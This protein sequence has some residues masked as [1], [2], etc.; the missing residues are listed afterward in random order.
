VTSVALR[1]VVGLVGFA[2][3][4]SALTSA[5]ITL[6]L[7][8][9]GNTRTA[10][11][12]IRMTR[13]VLTRTAGR[14]SARRERALALLAPVALL[15]M[16]IA[17]L[18]QIWVGF[19]GLYLAAGLEPVGDTALDAVWRALFLSGSSLL[20]LGFATGD[21]VVH[22]LLT[23]TEATLGL[24]VVTLL[25]AYLPTMYAAF[26]QRETQV[27]LL[28]VRAGTP[29]SASEML[30]RYHRIGNDH[31]LG[32]AMLEWEEWFAQ[33]TETHTTLTTLPLFRSSDPSQSWVTAAGTVLDA[34]SLLH[35][36]V[37]DAPKAPAALCIRAGFLAL[38]AIADEWALPYDADPS[39]G[40][41]IAI[42]REEFDRAWER[43]RDNGNEL[44]DVEQAWVDFA[45][46]RVNYDTPLLALAEMLE[47]PVAPWTS[48]RP[49]L[50][51]QSRMGRASSMRR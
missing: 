2:L 23:F 43:L 49:P 18:L 24:G 6:V 33:L 27:A 20:T 51:G 48:D 44:V 42:S 12:V 35:A 28:A 22:H 10:H 21:R 11:R 5:I 9:G 25:I 4:G 19:A 15:L 26:S 40:D 17:W 29:P 50:T 46:W 41:P 36:A 31:E 34:A 13:W 8:R 32:T 16:P 38:R 30:W 14:G 39:P 37:V 7:P 3:V 47:A 45:G 1:V